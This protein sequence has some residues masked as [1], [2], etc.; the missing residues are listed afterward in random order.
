[1]ISTAAIINGEN[2]YSWFIG[3]KMQFDHETGSSG[4]NING[5][6]GY[7]NQSFKGQIISCRFGYGIDF[8]NVTYHWIFDILLEF[9][10]IINYFLGGNQIDIHSSFVSKVKVSLYKLVG[11]KCVLIRR[12]HGVP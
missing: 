9:D 4:F 6:S 10:P 1:M 5:Q 7:Q 11:G 2:G 8:S 12:I 3:P